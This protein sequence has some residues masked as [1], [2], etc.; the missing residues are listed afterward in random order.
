MPGKS[1]IITLDEATTLLKLSKPTL[2]RLVQSKTIP[3]A[4]VGG[5]WRFSREQLEDFVKDPASFKK[6]KRVA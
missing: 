4:K 3:A 6:S 5:Q 1:D 2:Y